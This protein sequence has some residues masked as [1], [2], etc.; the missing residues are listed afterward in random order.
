MVDPNKATKPAEEPEPENAG[1]LPQIEEQLDADEAEFRALRSDLDAVK[2]AS[3]VGIVAISVG[4]APA[5]NEFFRTHPSFRAIVP[6]VN[7][8][9]GMEKAYFAVAK[10]MI[11]P[12][13]SIGISVSDHALYLTTTS[14][15]ATRVVPVRQASGDREQNEYDRTKELALVQAV[16]E[17]V[18]LYTDEKN[19]CYK[20][21]PA[22]PGRGPIRGLFAKFVAPE[23]ERPAGAQLASGK[24]NDVWALAGPRDELE[25]VQPDLLER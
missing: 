9:Q 1:I 23:L 17:W 3:A 14:G 7:V 6:I 19:K 4:K 25:V 8:E 11:Q 5:R 18:R 2:G 24:T 10:D 13:E 15:G 21:F 22:H 16:D 12:L 20:V